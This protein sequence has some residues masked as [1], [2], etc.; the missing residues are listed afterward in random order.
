MKKHKDEETSK[1]ECSE[2]DLEQAAGGGQ[3]FFYF[4]KARR[5][6][7]GGSV[8][9]NQPPRIQAFVPL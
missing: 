7:L 9:E 4:V 6:G 2:E 1:D 5:N 8:L 3:T